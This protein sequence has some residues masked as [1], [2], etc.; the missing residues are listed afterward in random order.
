[1]GVCLSNKLWVREIR[2]L[3][4]RGHQTA[5]LSTD[6]QAGLTRIGASIPSAKLRTGFARW[7]QE[8]YFKYMRE[9][10]SLDKLADYSLE[11]IAEPTQVINPIYRDLDG[12]VRSQVGKLNRMLASFGAMH[13]AGTLDDEKLGPFLHKKAELQEAI[14]QQKSVFADS[15]GFGSRAH[16]RAIAVA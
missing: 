6:Y 2:K 1:V 4:E 10:Y 3:T 7:S 8:N 16:C 14:E 5:I 12:K 15:C 13:F 9:H 11:T